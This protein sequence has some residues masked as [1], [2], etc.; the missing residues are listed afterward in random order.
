M[1]RPVASVER[2]ASDEAGFVNAAEAARALGVTITTLYAYV[3][4]KGIRTQ[5]VTGSRQT[6]YWWPDIDQIRRKEKRAEV[7]QKPV[8][9]TQETKITLMTQRGPYYR[10]TSALELAKTHTLE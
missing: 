8:G 6:R 5:R 7:Q 10:G 4:R 1:R 2:R 3:G 9:V